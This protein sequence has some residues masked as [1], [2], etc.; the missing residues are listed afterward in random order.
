VETDSATS[1]TNTQQVAHELASS[2]S[3]AVMQTPSADA[4]DQA[5]VDL[6]ARWSDPAA[7]K[8]FVFLANSLERLPDAAGRYRAIKSNKTAGPESGYRVPAD[9]PDRATMA[10][11][12]LSLITQQ[13]MA[14]FAIPPRE[15]RPRRGWILMPL[16]AFGMISSIGFLVAHATGRVWFKSLPMLLLYAVVTAMFPWKRL[17]E[18]QAH[19]AG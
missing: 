14:K 11:L 7:H 3:D 6:V 18:A 16:S 1:K 15:S 10:E 9:L 19:R 5:W 12:G 2:T 8:T 13:A 4:F 17:R